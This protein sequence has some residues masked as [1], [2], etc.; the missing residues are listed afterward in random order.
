[1]NL[2]SEIRTNNSR[3]V[4]PGSILCRAIYFYDFTDILKKF[5]EPR[6][7]VA[8]TTEFWSDRSGLESQNLSL[9]F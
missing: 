6:G 1:M 4:D 3:A 9:I 8:C 7:T 5:Q 2:G